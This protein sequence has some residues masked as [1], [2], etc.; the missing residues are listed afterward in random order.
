MDLPPMQVAVMGC[1]VNGPGEARDAD[2]GIAAGPGR[3]LLFSKGKQIGWVP[4]DRLVDALL[5]EAQRLGEEIRADGADEGNGRV[6]VTKGAG[7]RQDGRAAPP[8]M[9]IGMGRPP[10]R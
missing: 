3:G 10:A 8:L 1:E 7:R 2:I 4:D 6:V 9:G 5:E